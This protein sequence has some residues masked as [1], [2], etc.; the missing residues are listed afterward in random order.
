MQRASA[1]E[2]S[3]VWADTLHAACGRAEAAAADLARRAGQRLSE[4]ELDLLAGTVRRVDAMLASVKCEVSQQVRETH[5]AKP[6]PGGCCA[7]G[8]A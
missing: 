5:R 7:T 1:S 4:P 3:A 8:W 2:S 6:P